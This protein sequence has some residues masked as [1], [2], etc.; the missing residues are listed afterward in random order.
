MSTTTIDTRASLAEEVRHLDLAIRYTD[1]EVEEVA[2]WISLGFLATAVDEL[3]RCVLT[4]EVAGNA[5]KAERLRDLTLR[6]Q[7]R[8]RAEC[9]DKGA[10]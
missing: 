8:N 6:V 7:A 5:M 1:D 4:H 10:R 9:T 3:W 2:T